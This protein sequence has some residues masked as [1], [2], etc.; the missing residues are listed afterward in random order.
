M[1]AVR[2]A[3][4][5]RHFRMKDGTTITPGFVDRRAYPEIPDEAFQ[6][7]VTEQV[8]RLDKPEEHQ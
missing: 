7:N 2:V 1:K 8:E 4:L 6:R 3:W 5:F